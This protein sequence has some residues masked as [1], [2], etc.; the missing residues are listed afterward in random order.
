MEYRILGRTGIRVS[1]IALGCEGFMNKSADEVKADLDFAI[2][3]GVN[4]ID[5]YSSN[6]DLRS[7][8]G[9]ALEGRRDGFV[10]QGHLCSAWENDQY[11]RTRDMAKTVDSFGLQMEQLRNAYIENGMIP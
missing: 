1:A 9:A 11:L 4:F 8:I 10:I 2:S 7:S 6:P 5:I 3:H